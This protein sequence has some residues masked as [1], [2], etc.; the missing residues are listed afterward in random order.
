MTKELR[1][2]AKQLDQWQSDL[3][4]LKLYNKYKND[5]VIRWKDSVQKV[6]AKSKKVNKK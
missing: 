6:I 2:K 5:P 4:I 1:K 3:N